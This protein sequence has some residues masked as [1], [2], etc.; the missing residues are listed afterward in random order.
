MSSAQFIMVHSWMTSFTALLMADRRTPSELNNKQAINVSTSM[1]S[2][3]KPIQIKLPH[4]G[5]KIPLIAS[6]LLFVCKI[7]P[8][9]CQ[10]SSS[11]TLFVEIRHSVIV[12]LPASSASISLTPPS[13]ICCLAPRM[14]FFSP[15]HPS[16]FNSI[17]KCL[18][19]SS[20]IWA[21]SSP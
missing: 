10:V 20:C 5:P 9:I 21:G 7:N 17:I 8:I 12:F 6:F 1:S 16:A 14:I 3:S 2:T 11:S 4:L 13:S 15:D 18:P 19:A